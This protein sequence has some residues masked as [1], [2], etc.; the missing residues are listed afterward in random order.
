MLLSLVCKMKA[1]LYQYV[2]SEWCAHEIVLHL[3]V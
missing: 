2:K 1:D 3:V